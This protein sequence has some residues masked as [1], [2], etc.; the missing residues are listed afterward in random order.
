ME[1][2]QHPEIFQLLHCFYQSLKPKSAQMNIRAEEY[3]SKTI[4]AEAESET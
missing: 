1:E 4:R 3:Q 2:L